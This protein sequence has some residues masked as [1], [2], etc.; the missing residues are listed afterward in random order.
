M[1]NGNECTRCGKKRI[2]V[3][4]WEEHIEAYPGTS[5]VKHTLY[6]CPD[7]DCQEKVDAALTAQKNAALERAA[8][9]QQREKERQESVARS[10]AKKKAGN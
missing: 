2:L 10:L 4:T 7:L 9:S 6:A 1:N 3:K 5:I 8:A